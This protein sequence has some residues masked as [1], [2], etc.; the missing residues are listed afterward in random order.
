MTIKELKQRARDQIKPHAVKRA[1]FIIP[2]I[3]TRIIFFSVLFSNFDALFHNMTIGA[4]SQ[5]INVQ[6]YSI[7][8]LIVI[9]FLWMTT[10]LMTKAF[11]IDS[12][13]RQISPTKS[14]RELN[15]Y[16]GFIYGSVIRKWGYHII[17]QIPTV[18]CLFLSYATTIK[19][20][21]NLAEPLYLI[22]IYLFFIANI[23]A[24][25]KK[26]MAP[27]IAYKHLYDSKQA[28]EQSKS[29]TRHAIIQYYKLKLSFIL[30][31]CLNFWTLGLFSLYIYQYKISTL[32]LFEE[33]I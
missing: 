15:M 17:Y 24:G 6:N 21:Y 13:S 14:I 19:Q 25:Y 16:S 20:H 5:W 23:F 10:T 4:L 31:D 29:M 3:I 11:V 27:Y 30:W 7:I 12:I 22:S 28:V 1:L 9:L 18:I 32:L 2:L 8:A 33:E 26:Q